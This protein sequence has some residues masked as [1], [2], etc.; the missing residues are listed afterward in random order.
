[1][2]YALLALLSA[3]YLNTTPTNTAKADEGTYKMIVDGAT[4][5]AWAVNEHFA[6]TAGHMC[7]EMPRDS[8]LVS[9]SGH[10]FT[11]HSIAWELSSSYNG[12]D[13]CVLYVDA[14]LSA[15]LVIADRMPAVGDE[16]GYVGYPLGRHYEGHGHYLGDTDGEDHDNDNDTFDAVCDH[17]AS[18]S[19]VFT[20]R[21]VWGVLVSLR[22]DPTTMDILPG[23]MGC[24]A[25]PLSELRG[26][27]DEA[28]VHYTSR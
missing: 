11:A 2:K 7:E 16:I 27:L 17:G 3:C 20:D 8:V 13:V 6:V 4:G 26:M 22:I 23:S 24:V 18:G 1:M 5:T 19:A 28:G 25:T 10:S 9:S 21:G 15:P 14:P 12:H